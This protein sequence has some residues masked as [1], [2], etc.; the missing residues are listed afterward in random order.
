MISIFFHIAGLV[1]K[2]T[3]IFILSVR[4]KYRE[5]DGVTFAL[6]KP[7]VTCLLLL[8]LSEGCKLILPSI[9][10]LSCL[11][12]LSG[13]LSCCY[14]RLL[15]LLSALIRPHTH[16]RC[17]IQTRAKG[18]YASKTLNY[19]EGNRLERYYRQDLISRQKSDSLSV[20]NYMQ[21]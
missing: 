4:V 16:L 17:I 3:P 6:V 1:V 18:G 12:L 13:D 21:T 7:V 19:F 9:L 20:G 10:H 8:A 15:S 5:R 14:T 2:K 11:T